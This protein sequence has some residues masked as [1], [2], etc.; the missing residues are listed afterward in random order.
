ME[1]RVP[2]NAVRVLITPEDGSA[3]FYAVL[4]RAD[5]P[6]VAGT[7]LNKAKLL[8]DTTANLYGVTSKTASPDELFQIL[9][10][11]V[12]DRV[13]K[14]CVFSADV[15]GSGSSGTDVNLA[16]FTLSRDDVQAYAFLIFEFDGTFTSTGTSTSYEAGLA[17]IRDTSYSSNKQFAS[18]SA[19]AGP[20]S[21]TGKRMTIAMN[22]GSTGTTD[23]QSLV[24][25]LPQITSGI[26]DSISVG[27]SGSTFSLYLVNST[28]SS[29]S[30]AGTFS[31]Y[32]VKVSE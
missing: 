19:L 26:L 23:S 11:A 21:I 4:T 10:P 32:G 18:L 30:A 29:S 17:L 13:K 1:D 3:P 27:P 31:V 15:N 25:V 24:F 9:S 14:E 8:S 16:Q 7:P 2:A 6:T 22:S 28:N 5:N 12:T 20:S